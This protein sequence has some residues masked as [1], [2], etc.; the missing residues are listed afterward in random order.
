[1]TSE[2]RRRATDWLI[3]VGTALAAA[4]LVGTLVLTIILQLNNRELIQQNHTLTE[5]NHVLLANSNRN[6]EDN[7]KIEKYLAQLARLEGNG[8]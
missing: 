2:G 7:L 4:I 8:K 3:V 6:H 1:M 5:Q